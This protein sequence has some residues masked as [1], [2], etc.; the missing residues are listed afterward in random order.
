MENLSSLPTLALPGILDNNIT[1]KC[2]KAV[3]AYL[4]YFGSRYVGNDIQLLCGNVLDHPIVKTFTLFCIMFQATDNFYLGSVMT[5]IFLTIQ[6]AM[7]NSESCRN[8]IDKT[9]MKKS[10]ERGKPW[11][12]TL[13]KPVPASNKLPS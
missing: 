12:S 8:Y 3:A 1:Y 5:I 10:E 6:Y 13:T 4:G 11:V 9:T 7:S 2:G